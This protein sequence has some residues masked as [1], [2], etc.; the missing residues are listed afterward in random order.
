M[1]HCAHLVSKP[2]THRRLSSKQRRSSTLSVARA[3]SRAKSPGDKARLAQILQEREKLVAIAAS[4]LRGARQDADIK[5]ARMAELMARGEDAISN[6]ESGQTEVTVADAILWARSLDL[7]PS[8][9]FD[10][11]IFYTRQLYAK[12]AGL[13]RF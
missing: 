4:V 10:R 11:L 12:K 6:M 7:D 3:T 9:L 5:Q 13:P 2:K 8:E 1:L